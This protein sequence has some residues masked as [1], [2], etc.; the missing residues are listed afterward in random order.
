MKQYGISEKIDKEINET[1][2]SLEI[3]RMIEVRLDGR[4]ERIQYSVYNIGKFGFLSRKQK[5]LSLCY[6]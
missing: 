6:T 2:G 3:Q 5:T 1:I 4:R